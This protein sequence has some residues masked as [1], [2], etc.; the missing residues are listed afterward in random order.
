MQ[1][2]R[3]ALIPQLLAA[4]EA[5]EVLEAFP[6]GPASVRIDNYQL[7]VESIDGNTITQ[8]RVTPLSLTTSIE[9]SDT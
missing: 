1:T 8:V 6:M 9:P 4:L 7:D 3:L 5:L 2:A